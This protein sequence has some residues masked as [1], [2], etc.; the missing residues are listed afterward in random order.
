MSRRAFIMLLSIFTMGA[1]FLWLQEDGAPGRIPA[2]RPFSAFPVTV[3]DWTGVRLPI[4]KKTAK[5]LNA[6]GTASILF[7]KTEAG[8]GGPEILFF[9][10]YYD[11]QTPEKNIHSPENCLPSSGWAVLKR[12]TVSLSL[13]QG[14]PPVRA[15]YD[16]I[17]K[18]LERQ[19]VLYWYQERGRTFSNDYLGRYYMI[20]DAL[21]MRRTD[22]AMV[23]VS[24]PIGTTPREALAQEVG[25][26]RDLVPL[27]SRFIPGGVADREVAQRVSL[28]FVEVLR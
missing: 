7:Q 15:S 16:I 1:G 19:L 11:R 18:G 14:G 4:D 28:P 26:L 22:G 3:G 10:V 6:D 23:R 9:G 24:M 21:L 17:Q 12:K 5:I 8:S 27:L 20:R 25:F 2:H 13:V